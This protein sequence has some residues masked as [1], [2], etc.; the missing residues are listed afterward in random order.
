[1]SFDN[2]F[3]E[4]TARKEQQQEAQQ[5]AALHHGEAV[6]LLM[7][8][9]SGRAFVRQFLELCG[10][11]KVHGP[12]Q[13][14]MLQYQEGLRAAGMW[15]FTALVHDNPEHIQKIVQEEE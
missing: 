8:S 6:R 14:E 2:L 13:T 15:L 4:Q 10:V 11:F 12:R 1:M 5:R 3:P 7:G 9:T